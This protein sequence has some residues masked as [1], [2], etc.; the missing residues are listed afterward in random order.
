MTELVDTLLI[1]L[2]S[3]GIMYLVIKWIIDLVETLWRE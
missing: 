1:V 2:S 3:M